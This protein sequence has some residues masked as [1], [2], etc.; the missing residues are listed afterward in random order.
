MKSVFLSNI[1]LLAICPHVAC[2]Q[3][4]VDIHNAVT[5]LILSLML[6]LLSFNTSDKK[7]PFDGIF[8]EQTSKINQATEDDDTV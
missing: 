1:Y 4:F 2:L 3:F 7:F 6:Y 5:I 8:N